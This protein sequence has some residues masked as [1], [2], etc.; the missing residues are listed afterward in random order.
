MPDKTDE[1][2]ALADVYAHALLQAADEKG[3][4]DE[5][6]AELADLIRYMDSDPEFARF[7]T[8]DSVDDEA[9]RVS[10]DKLFRG[11][12]RDLLLNLTQVLN[13]RNRLH[14]IRLVYR[15]VE[16]RMEER[17][18]QQE[19]LIQTAMPLTEDLRGLLKTRIGEYVGKEALIADQVVPELIGGLVIHINDVQI[20]ASV[21]SRIQDMRQQLSD[22]AVHEIHGRKGYEA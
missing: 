6:A 15:C 3:T 22:R 8:A 17:H 13:N 18:H 16:L 9:R 12:M 21:A 20:D 4:T 1:L 19:V 5:V 7:L 10:L 11:R 14:M 2:M